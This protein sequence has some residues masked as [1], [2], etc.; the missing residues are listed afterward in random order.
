VVSS[1][2]LGGSGGTAHA[3]INLLF[4]TFDFVLLLRKHSV[5]VVIEGSR[6]TS[7]FQIISVVNLLRN[8]SLICRKDRCVQRCARLPLPG[9]GVLIHKYSQ[10]RDPFCFI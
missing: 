5:Q 3:T 8:Q 7:S 6:Y 4:R 10:A 9:T 1:P 2:V